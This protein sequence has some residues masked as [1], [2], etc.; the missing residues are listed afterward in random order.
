MRYGVTVTKLVFPRNRGFTLI[1][2]LVVIAIIAILASLLLPALG[3]SR[4]MAYK[5]D[6]TNNQK[7]VALALFMYADDHDGVFPTDYDSANYPT[8][9]RTWNSRLKQYLDIPETEIL[10]SWKFADIE[11]VFRCESYRTIIDFNGNQGMQAWNYRLSWKRSTIS[12]SPGDLV[13]LADPKP[14]W[15]DGQG[16]K[17]DR[18]FSKEACGSWQLT[19]GGRGMIGNIHPLPGTR[20]GNPSG[21]AN[22]VFLDGAASSAPNNQFPNAS[23]NPALQ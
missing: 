21:M 8:Y 23:I 14:W 20:V 12:P 2:L 13:L 4:Q 11:P 1:E 18:S 10:S 6:C 22:V 15:W 3:R 19:D 7:Q 17:V 5:I 9:F 16:W